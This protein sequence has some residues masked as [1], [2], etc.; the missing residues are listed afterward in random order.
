MRKVAYNN[1]IK[2]EYELQGRRKIEGTG[3]WETKF[4]HIG[5]FHQWASAYE[6]FELGAGNYTVA[7]I[8]NPDGTISE[9]LPSNLKFLSE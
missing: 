7:L 4:K 2:P 6:E 9:V 3:C 8:E 5:L 1:W